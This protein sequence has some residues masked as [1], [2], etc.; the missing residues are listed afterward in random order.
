M[1]I[2]FNTSPR[3]YVVVGGFFILFRENHFDDF[4]YSF[5]S[6]IEMPRKFLIC[7]E[8]TARLFVCALFYSIYRKPFGRIVC[9]KVVFFF[10]PIWQIDMR[11]LLLFDIFY[12]TEAESML[13]VGVLVQTLERNQESNIPYTSNQKSQIVLHSHLHIKSM[14]FT[15]NARTV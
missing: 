4:S 9:Y 12:A 5:I 13:I 14:R 15:F 6:W 8:S 7:A 1:Y 3:W 11:I 10:A 2:A